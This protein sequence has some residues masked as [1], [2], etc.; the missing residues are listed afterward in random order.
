[1]SDTSKANALQYHSLRPA[2]KLTITPTKPLANQLDLS[3]AYSPG[4]AYPCR[5]IARDPLAA[6]QYTTRS[7]LVGVVTNGSAVLGLGGIGPLASKPVMEGKAVLFKKFANIDAFDIEVSEDDPERLIEVVAALEP[8]F[9]AINLEDIKAP[10]CFVVEAALRDRLNIPVF[11]D[12]QHG[13][14]IVVAAAIRNALELVGKKLSGAKLV[15][16]GGGAA[17]L[18]CLDLLVELGLP[19]E[20]IVLVDLHGVVYVGRETDMNPFKSRYAVETN[21]RT[22]DD[23][24]DGADIFLGLSAPDVLSAE[25]TRRMADKPIIMALAN[26]DPEIN[27]ELARRARPDAIIA[28]GRSDFPNQVN[29]VLCFPFIFRGALDV[30]ATDINAAM[31]SACVDAIA[32][33][34]RQHLTDEVESIYS[35]ESIEFGPEYLIPKPFDPRLC[36]DVSYAV[37]VAAMESGVATRP[38]EDLKAYKLRLDAFR[39]SSQLFMQPVVDVARRDRERL[40]FAEGENRNV[41]RVLQAVLTEKIADPAVV[42]RRAVVERRL[43]DLGINL[44]PDTDFEL[45]DP[46]DDRRYDD[47]WQTYHAL[48]CRRGVSV[49]DARTVMRTNTTAI[50]ACMLVKND[51]D[52]MICG[53][54][55]RF[56]HHLH[57]IIEIVGTENPDTLVSS[58]AVLLLPQGPLFIADAYIRV[59]PSVEDLARTTIAAAQ[60]VSDFG[61]KPK[62]ALMSHSNF[63]SSRSAEARKMRDAVRLI[64]ELAPELECDGEMH[65]DAALDEDVRVA[66]NRCTTLQGAANLLIMPSLDAANIAVELLRSTADTMMIGPI[67]SGTAKPAHIVTPSTTTKG[68]FNMSA[69]AVADVYRR[70]VRTGS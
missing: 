18:A 11:H 19:R 30:G 6:A 14:A 4:V 27:P 9:G 40:V 25:M 21:K 35:D 12:D 65:A 28:T 43:D 15:A 1:M 47:Y 55:G 26:P 29:N 2:G 58:L 49:V 42:G 62:V 69:L 50:A 45:V 13:T 59:S 8:T 48:A 33:L 24:I 61:V 51:A 52:A 54:E 70:S 41:L 57:H 22:L 3:Q 64:R 7:N 31:M 37:A 10:D 67:L 60:R 36:V 66:I 23:V 53:I 32:N 20:N 39:N 16:T 34:A 38:I 5:E 17:S 68:L 44:K 56:A 63:G 46:E